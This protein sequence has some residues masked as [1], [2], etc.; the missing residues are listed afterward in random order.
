QR[1]PVPPAVMSLED[2]MS[3]RGLIIPAIWAIV[4][5]GFRCGDAGPVRADDPVMPKVAADSIGMKFAVIPT[6]E[7]D[8]GSLPKEQDADAAWREW[9]QH[10]VRISAF[11]LGVTEVTIGQFRRFVEKTDRRMPADAGHTWDNP[12][13]E[14]T[15]E[16]PVSV[17]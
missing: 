3:A 13:Y 12:G 10:R 8:M 2:A 5:T 15:E 1:S 14:R 17:V 16:H 4:L 9:P 11:R 7:F 6:G